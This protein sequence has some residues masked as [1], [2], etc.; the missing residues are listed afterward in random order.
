MTKVLA[1]D[2]RKKNSSGPSKVEVE[3]D[4]A[5]IQEFDTRGQC[6]TKYEENWG[7]KVEV[8]MDGAPCMLYLE[9]FSRSVAHVNE[10]RNL[11]KDQ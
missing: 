3:Y 8:Q 9:L 2:L 4:P 11:L 5:Q 7:K 1:N 10:N 6:A